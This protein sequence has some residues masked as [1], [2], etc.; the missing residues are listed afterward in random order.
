MV[1]R[2]LVGRLVASA[3]KAPLA[4]L[5]HG[6]I[7]QKCQALKL[8]TVRPSWIIPAMRRPLTMPVSSTSVFES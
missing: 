1:H 6:L 2:R 7:H 4:H 5:L 3:H 8:A